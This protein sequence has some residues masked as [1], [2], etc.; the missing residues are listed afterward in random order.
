MHSRPRRQLEEELTMMHI[1]TRRHKAARAAITVASVGMLLAAAFATSAHAG[2]AHH[3]AAAKQPASGGSYSERLSNA[4]D[5]LDPQKTGSATSNGL[6]SDILDTLLSIDDKGH[7]VA[8]LATGYK[9]SNGGTHL[10][11]TLRKN[12]KFSNGDPFTA[13]DVKFTFDRAI[14]PATK[15]PVTAGRSEER[16]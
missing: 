3:A 1:A 6:D 10:T 7:Y 2:A 16:R 13:T 5:C 15:S 12:V 8:D 4:A 11:F 9:V 14:D